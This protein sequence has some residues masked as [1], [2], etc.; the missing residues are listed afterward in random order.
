MTK[1]GHLVACH[2]PQAHRRTQPSVAVPLRLRGS[3]RPDAIPLTPHI[4]AQMIQRKLGIRGPLRA[5]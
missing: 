1:D 3:E 2:E 4:F 5:N